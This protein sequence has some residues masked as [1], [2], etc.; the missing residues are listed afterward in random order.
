MR[1]RSLTPQTSSTEQLSVNAQSPHPGLRVLL[2]VDSLAA[3]GTELNAVRTVEAL[4]RGGH[5]A[6]LLALRAAGPLLERCV[7]GGVPV[8]E[9]R[10]PPIRQGGVLRRVGALVRLILATG[11]EVV[12]TQDRYT[13]ALLVPWAR[14][15]GVRVVA[16]RRWWDLQPSRAIRAG[17][18]L[19]FRLAH[20]VTA[21]SQ[22]VAELV[23]KVDGVPPQKITVVPNFL[24]EWALE[25][26]GEA[27]RRMLRERLG[28]PDAAARV[29]GVVAN[30]RPVKAH[31]VLLEAMA[32]VMRG[33]RDVLLAL[34]GDGECRPALERQA[35]KLGIAQ[36]VTFAGARSEP[37]N[38]HAAFDVS[39]LASYSEGFPNTVVEGMAAGNP[40]VAT[41]V[42]GTADAI[43]D[44]VTGLLVPAGS[45]AALAAALVRVLDDPTLARRLGQA[46]LQRAQHEFR[47][48]AVIPRLEM[49]YSSLLAESS[50]PRS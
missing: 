30:L 3:G 34:V 12:H 6:R 25:A 33:R 28:I 49:L 50:M 44:E 16:S 29:V 38:W 1:T 35:R 9:L 40:V 17:N 10:V 48:D 5:D 23:R 45:A 4:R 27:E 20:H 37:V 13:N 18:R 22:R 8:T 46:A 15:A 21:N 11:A 19:A 47:A 24:D 41:D 7:R 2:C 36:R 32:I 43:R 31:E 26:A 39:V 42:G 14:L